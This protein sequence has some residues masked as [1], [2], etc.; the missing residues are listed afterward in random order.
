MF[1]CVGVGRQVGIFLQWEHCY[2]SVKGYIGAMDRKCETIGEATRCL[3]Q[4]GIKHKS[5]YIH[6]EDASISLDEYCTENLLLIPAEVDYNRRTL[7]V[8]GYGLYA[9]VIE[10]HGK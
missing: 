9:K 4:Q 6:T 2:E 3:N 1:Y 8:I 5:I 7:F 10:L